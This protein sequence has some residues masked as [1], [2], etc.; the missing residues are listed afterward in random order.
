M[1]IYSYGIPVFNRFAAIGPM[2]PDGNPIGTIISYMG[3]TAPD[4]YLICDGKTYNTYDYPDLADFF[5]QQ[6]GNKYYFGGSDEKFAVPDMRNLFVRGYHGAA[7]EQLSDEIGKKQEG[8]EHTYLTTD[9]NGRYIVTGDIANNDLYDKIIMGIKHSYVSGA[10][11]GVSPCESYYT[12]RPVNMAVLYCIKA[13]KAEPCGDIYSE[14]ERV[15]GRWID[16][17]LIYRKVLIFNNS[18]LIGGKSVKIGDLPND[19]DKCIRLETFALYPNYTYAYPSPYPYPEIYYI[20][21]I[22]TIE[23][24][25]EIYSEGSSFKNNQENFCIIEYTK[26]TD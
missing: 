3:K 12:A 16:G 6:F 1:Q 9:Q 13:V 7:S 8:T 19:M 4:D 26:T 2:G 15:I 25:I 14:E 10:F 24:I 20:L 17:K 22:N 21:G 23:N 5:E 18:V 11:D